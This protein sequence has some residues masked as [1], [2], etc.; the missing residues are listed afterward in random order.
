MPQAAPWFHE[1][2]HVD[3]TSCRPSRPD[4]EPAVAGVHKGAYVVADAEGGKPDVIILAAGSTLGMSVE[5]YEQ[6]KK[7]GVKA[8]VVSMP[9]WEMFEHHCAKHDPAYREAVLPASVTARVAVEKASTF[10]WH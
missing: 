7:D 6:L 1:V 9:S 10:G 3:E 8:R 2:P 5:A 4:P